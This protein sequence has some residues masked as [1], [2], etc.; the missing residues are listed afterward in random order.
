M[1]YI[2]QGISLIGTWMQ[3][4]AL[5]WLVFRLT[6]SPFLLGI[7]SFSGELP[8]FLTTTFAGVLIDRWNK[9]RLL[10]ITQVL[11]MIQALILSVLFFTKT[12]SIWHIIALSIFMGLINAFDMPCRQSLIIDLLEKKEDIGNAI[13]LNSSMFNLARLIGPTIAGIL[14]AT[15]GEGICFLLNAVSYLSAILALMAM[16]IKQKVIRPISKSIFEEL[17]QGFSY[18]YNLMPIRYILFLIIVISL[19]GLSY[20]VLM[21]VV[22]RVMLKGGPQTMGFLMTG[23]GIGALTGAFYLASRKNQ[24][25]LINI[26]P[27]ATL[28]F[29]FGLITLS[30]SRTLYL[31][32][33]IMFFVGFG[34]MSFNATSNTVLQTIVDDDKRGRVMSLYTMSFIG[35][36]PFGSLLAG[37]LANKIG[38]SLTILIGGII[39]VIIAGLFIHQL[40][41]LRKETNLI[42]PKLGITTEISEE[43]QTA[44]QIDPH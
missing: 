36:T 10:I 13:A 38:A 30:A 11:A 41:K 22:A 37:T 18:A 26:I 20:I 44:S 4:V 43:I 39:S 24:T 31:S 40:P 16:K 32:I 2:G 3:R 17:R 21:P 23:S 15:T 25:G 14:I 7:V 9:R 5:G 8:I 35:T 33:L 12:I 42:S 19:T 1:Y 27:I 29:G 34:M 6:N 28:I